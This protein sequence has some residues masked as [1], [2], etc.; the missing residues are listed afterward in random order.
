ML[1]ELKLDCFENPILYKNIIE[2][3]K[4]ACQDN[5]RFKS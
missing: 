4:R 1:H 3:F 5:E 2:I